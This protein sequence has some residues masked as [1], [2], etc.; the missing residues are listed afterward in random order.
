MDSGAEIV[1]P[2]PTNGDENGVRFPVVR[3]ID[4]MLEPVNGLTVT[5]RRGTVGLL[6][7]SRTMPNG[8]ASDSPVPTR[9]LLTTVRAPLERSMRTT[10]AVI[11]TVAYTR[12]FAASSVRKVDPWMRVGDVSPALAE[13]MLRTPVAR[14]M[15]T[16]WSSIE[17]RI[18]AR[19]LAASMTISF[20]P[21]PGVVPWA[22]P[23]ES[24]VPMPSERRNAMMLPV[25][26]SLRMTRLRAA[27][28]PTLRGELMNGPRL[29]IVAEPTAAEFPTPSVL[30]TFTVVVATGTGMTALQCAKPSVVCAAT[31]LTLT[32]V[33]PRGS[34]AV[35]RTDTRGSVGVV[36]A[37]RKEEPHFRGRGIE[38]PACAG[39]GCVEIAGAIACS[40]LNGVRAIGETADRVRNRHCRELAA[41]HARFDGAACF[42]ARDGER[43]R[44]DGGGGRR[45][46][47]DGRV[48]W[49]GVDHPGEGH[50]VWS[51]GC[52]RHPAR[53]PRKCGCRR[54]GS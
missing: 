53:E 34:C 7:L 49:R 27:S 48:G 38:R 33:T 3:S 40:E 4:R 28:N 25:L 32:A 37:R 22:G 14:L 50:G 46:G 47:G 2:V 6:T 5:S 26:W 43:G 9:L 19:S 30:E 45:S 31:P 13:T 8:L 1:G 41:V 29:I 10:D 39:G 11:P 44:I 24:I 17:L 51:R 18:S 54:R 12:W 36:V 16:S 42:R 35:P 52:R 23:A 15:A 21:L 20:R